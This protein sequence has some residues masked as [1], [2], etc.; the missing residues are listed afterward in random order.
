MLPINSGV[1][2]GETACKIA[3]KWGYLKKKIPD[4]QAKIVFAENNYWGRTLAAISSSTDPT[5]TEHYGPYMPG[6]VVI[7]YDDL[8]ALE[9]TL[10]SDPNICAFM[11][12]PIQGEAG[13]IVPSPGYLKG[14]RQ[15][16][17]KYNVLWIDDEV[18]TGLGRTGKMLAVEHEGVK[19]D[20]VC[21]GKALSGGTMPVIRPT[22]PVP[23]IVTNV[24]C[25]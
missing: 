15:L 24:S 10:K 9:E 16:C 18:Q 3:R 23:A 13:I 20:L 12:E 14:V 1:E 8:K 17:T 25:F 21:L 7:P 11:V 4:N 22:Q 6:F 5:C 2:A 19:P